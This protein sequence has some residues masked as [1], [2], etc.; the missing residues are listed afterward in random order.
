M[1]SGGWIAA[2]ILMRPPHRGH[3]STSMKKL[4][5]SI[6]AT[7]NSGAG[8]CLQVVDLELPRLLVSSPLEDVGDVYVRLDSRAPLPSGRT[9]DCAPLRISH[10]SFGCSPD[11]SVVALTVRIGTPQLRGACLRTAPDR[12]E[13]LHRLL[14][15]DIMVPRPCRQQS[16]WKSRT[17]LAFCDSATRRTPRHGQMRT[18]GAEV[19][20]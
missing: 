20:R 18:G 13:I 12:V 9:D 11:E 1:A 14:R 16:S 4:F 19:V 15:P 6:R 17:S 7:N 5:S 8:P 3:S 10:S 2:T